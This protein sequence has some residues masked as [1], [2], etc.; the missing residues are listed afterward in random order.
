[1]NKQ[2]NDINLEKLFRSH[3]TIEPNAR[4][5]ENIMQAIEAS[6][7]KTTTAISETYGAK[8]F[9]VIPAIL[10]FAGFVYF[11]VFGNGV[12]IWSEYDPILFP[13]FKS[14]WLSLKDIFLSFKVSSVT[15]IILGGLGS[16][17]MVERILRKLQSARSSMHLI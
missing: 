2:N 14:I 13:I 7:E 1:M 6:D 11:F 15:I 5:T 3:G 16:L 17:F 9:F 4:L 12:L 10:A 8:Y